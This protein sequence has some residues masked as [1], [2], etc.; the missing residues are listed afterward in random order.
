MKHFLFVLIISTFFSCKQSEVSKQLPEVKT[1]QLIALFKASQTNYPNIS[2]HRGGK[3]ILK[4]PENCLETI[5]YISD[6]ISAIYEVD[7]AQTKDGQLVLLHDN[8][9][10]RTTNGS[11]KID[12]LTYNEIKDFKLVD[13]FGNVTA[14]KIPLFSDVLSWCV[15]HNVVLTIDIKKTVRQESVIREIKKQSAEDISI[16]ITYTVDQ[17][18]T[19][20]QLAPELLLSVSARNDEEFDRL[21]KTEIPTANML[22]FTGTRLSDATLFKRLHENNI[23]C[24]LGTLGN[25]D[26]SAAAKGDAIYRE[27]NKRGADILA[28]DRPFNAFEALNN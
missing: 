4:Y 28:T 27:W 18:K 8:S 14:Y 19:A 16:I 24:M 13:D 25:L 20:Y 1:S 5:K 23:V 7:V 22:A 21:L 9:I 10:D 12:Q 17:A 3:G 2:V 11:G 15:K 6:S 26:K